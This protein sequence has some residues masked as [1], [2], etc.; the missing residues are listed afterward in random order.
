MTSKLARLRQSLLFPV[1]M[2]EMRSR[3]R[4]ARAPALVLASGGMAVIIGIF[5][6][7]NA[8]Y[9][10]PMQRTETMAR[11]GRLLFTSLVELEAILAALIAPALTAGAIAAEDE[12]Q[13]LDL[14]LLT[15][16]SSANIVLG[17]L[18][19]S[20]SFLTVILITALPVTA[21]AFVFGGVSPWQLVFSQLLV[22]AVV[23]CF[24]AFGLCCSVYCRRTTT[25]LV[26]AY[27]IS[28]TW[29][30]LLPLLKVLF[31]WQ[32]YSYSFNNGNILLSIMIPTLLAIATLMLMA[33]VPTVAI[34]TLIGL[35][36]DRRLSRVTIFAIWG[37]CASL[38]LGV[39]YIP[40]VWNNLEIDYLLFANPAIAL[41][42]I[43]NLQTDDK[44]YL[45]TG[46]L[47]N[48]IEWMSAIS[49]ITLMLLAAWGATALAVLRIQRRAYP[50]KKGSG[51]VGQA[52]KQATGD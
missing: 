2:K 50:G 32:R 13:T 3:M 31:G 17:K 8:D 21:L 18:F 25:A 29:V 12:K 10:D 48:G 45:I 30:A 23:L 9:S 16:L 28:I 36:R 39:L 49:A 38:A 34:S 5:I 35:L 19:S 6:L 14:L 15:R 43:L 7:L 27:V 33:T 4:G 1:L 47:L 42:Q 41:Y 11:T 37:L 44:G 52:A 20:L 40:A 51:K 22:I 46:V 24:G 26:I